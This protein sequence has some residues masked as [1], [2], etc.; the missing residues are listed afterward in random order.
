MADLQDP[1]SLDERDHARHPVFPAIEG[2]ARR[3]KIV[4]ECELVIEQ[5]KEKPQELF[6][7]P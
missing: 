5:P 4:R 7:K 1:V 6:H 2:N 3:H